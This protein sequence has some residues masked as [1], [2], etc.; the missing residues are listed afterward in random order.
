MI[1]ELNENIEIERAY[2]A[3]FFGKWHKGDVTDEEP[4]LRPNPNEGIF[5]DN[6]GGGFDEYLSGFHDKGGDNNSSESPSSDSYSSISTHFP[7]KKNQ[8]YFAF[9][10]TFTTKL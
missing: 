8:K 10:S 4:D 3:E 5:E 2:L 6:F 7:T 1:S 9:T